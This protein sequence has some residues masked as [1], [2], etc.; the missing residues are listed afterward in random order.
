MIDMTEIEKAIDELIEAE[1]LLIK[2]LNDR[3][4]SNDKVFGL[5][6]DKRAAREHLLELIKEVNAKVERPTIY[7]TPKEPLVYVGHESPTMI[8]TNDEVKH[9]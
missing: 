2:G 6:A 9:E 1:R 8:L 3:K 7:E 4:V 5:A